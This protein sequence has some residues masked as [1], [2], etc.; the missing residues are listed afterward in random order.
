MCGPV[1]AGSAV[2]PSVRRGA[3]RRARPIRV[4]RT[5][6]YNRP[7]MP[8]YLDHAATTPAPP[9]GAR[10]D[11]AV[12]RRDVR[13]PV[14]G[15]RVRPARRA[16]RSTTPTSGSPARSAP[17]PREIVFT[18]G[19]TE[20]SNLALKGAAWAGRARGARIVTSAVEHHAVGHALG[21]LEKFGFEIVE[22]AG[23]PLR[24]G[25]P[26]RRR[27]GAHR[28]DDPGRRHARQQRGRH[29]PADRRDRDGS[30][31]RTA[32]SLLHVDAVQAAPWLRPRRRGARRRPRRPRAPTRSRA[33]RASG[34]LWIRKGTHL[35]AQQHGGVAGAPPAGRARRTSAGAVGMATAFELVARRAA[36]TVARVRAPARPARGGRARPS[37]ASSSPAT[38]SSGCR[39]S[40]R[41]SS[42]D[43]D[44][45]SVDRGARPR[46]R[47]PRPPGRPAPRGSTEVSHVLAAMGY[48]D[49]EA[50]GA[51][52]LSLGPDRRPTPRS[53]RRAGSCPRSS[54]RL[55]GH[56][57]AG[58]RP[59]ESADHGRRRAMSRILVAM[60]GGVD[61]SVAAAL[62]HEQGHEVVGVWMRLHDVADTLLRATAAA[63]ARPTPPTTRAG[64]P[65]GSGIPFYVMNLEREFGAGRHRAVPRGLPRRADAQPVRRLQ[66]RRQVRRAAGQGPPPVRLRG[67][68]DRPLRPA[69]GRGDRRRARARCSPGPR[70]RPRTR[71]TSCTACA[72]TSCGTAASRW[73]TSPSRRSATSPAASAW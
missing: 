8:I 3:D 37:T 44:G 66:H 14:V 53:T 28:P 34:A 10:G 41:S 35:L 7:T 22:R 45:A 57:A 16:R 67:R 60:S 54:R 6:A 49:D 71:P 21:H 47:S 32:A 4:T 56:V 62:L 63:A 29:D 58:R 59:P 26:G 69:P 24:A 70:T 2:R 31:G 36:G 1:T 43:V 27:G 5:R 38:P 68:G 30:S 11:A 13:Q 23:R 42:R 20:A 50:R 46:G 12:P 48:P 9:R 19:G 25:R 64:S 72:R 39:T 52:R 33:P 17:T 40:C 73:A 65:R 61:S 18:S 51:L 55:R 15:A